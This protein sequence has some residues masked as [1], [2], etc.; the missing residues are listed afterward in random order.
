MLRAECSNREVVLR[1]G[2]LNSC[3]ANNVDALVNDYKSA[4]DVVLLGD[5]SMDFVNDII[6]AVAQ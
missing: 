2:F 5:T 4:F 3:V 6:A 1:I